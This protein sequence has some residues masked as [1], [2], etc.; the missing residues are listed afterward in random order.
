MDISRSIPVSR[1]NLV[2]TSAALCGAAA[3]SACS[4]SGQAGSSAGDARADKQ[5]I[6]V[7]SPSNEP[8]G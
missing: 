1:R 5:V 6:V 4:E 8:E 7:M 2:R 3:L